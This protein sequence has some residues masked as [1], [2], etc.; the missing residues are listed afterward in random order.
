[1]ENFNNSEV[2]VAILI[3]AE[4]ISPEYIGIIIDE[5]NK[6]GNIAFRNIYGDWSE[7][8]LKAWKDVAIEYSL[9]Q[10][11]QYSVV[12]GKSSSDFALVIDAMDILYRSNIDTFIVV[13]SDSDFSRL[14]TRLREGGKKVIGMGESKT[15]RALT[16]SCHAFVYLDKVKKAADKVRRKR[17]VYKRQP[18]S[19]NVNDIP[20]LEEIIDDLRVIISENADDK[21]WAYWSH[22]NNM[23]LKKQPGFDPRNYGYTGRSID[24]FEKNDFEVYREGLEV[25]IRYPSS[26]IE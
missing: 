20:A 7:T 12:K 8:R 1:M 23:L 24:F 5:G 14:V 10:K 22:A 18:S 3:D 13:S 11:Q 6:Q 9:T 25:F 19:K 26:E 17:R 4:N 15:P 16:N 2:N 21:G